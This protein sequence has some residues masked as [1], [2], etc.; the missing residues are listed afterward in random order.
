MDGA[1]SR[2]HNQT[3]YSWTALRARCVHNKRGGCQVVAE[4]FAQVDAEGA[5]WF[6]ACGEGGG[7]RL[8]SGEA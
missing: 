8:V 7:N 2:S 3:L 5:L 4:A 1:K 6:E